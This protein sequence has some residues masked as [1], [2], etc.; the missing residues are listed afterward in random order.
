MFAG[1]RTLYKMADDGCDTLYQHPAYITIIYIV[2]PPEIP[3]PMP[4]ENIAELAV[5]PKNTTMNKL[6]YISVYEDGPAKMGMGIVG[7]VF[8]G[9][10]IFAVI[11]LDCPV[12]VKHVRTVGARNIRKRTICRR[13]QIGKMKNKVEQSPPVESSAEPPPTSAPP[14]N[15]D[16]V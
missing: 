4:V 3:E 13:K 2:V 9:A 14:D 7:A 1:V 6:R 5:D 8:I 16:L 15:A 11:V 10:I 12:F